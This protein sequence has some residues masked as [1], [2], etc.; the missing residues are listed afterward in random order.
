M[1]FPWIAAAIVGSSLFGAY[2]SSKAAGT[3]AAGYRYAADLQMQQY[4]QTRSDL[5]PWRET[6]GNALAELADLYGV[7]LNYGETGGGYDPN[8]PE[9]IPDPNWRDLTGGI[10]QKQAP[11]IRNPAY[12][13]PGEGTRE[14][15]QEAAFDRF[16]TSPGYQFRLDE[17][18][19]ALERSGASRG[20]LNSGAMGRSLVE[21]G[22]GLASSEFGNYANR[23]AS[24]AGT[25]QT[26][27]TTTGQIGIAAAGQAG[28]FMGQAG[29]ARASGYAGA[30]NAVSGGV[31]NAMYMY[32]SQAWNPY[33]QQASWK[34]PD[35]GQIWRYPG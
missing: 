23:L 19:R 15:R 5:A 34:N 7:G 4:Q 16:F 12:V 18:I 6:G 29:T 8:E 28:M 25:G 22:Q 3:Q 35:T 14:G 11:M 32:G 31:E 13:A 26:A 9:M 33:Q 1:A 2:S 10:V 21:Y 30:A 24:L 20:K 17:G 27:A